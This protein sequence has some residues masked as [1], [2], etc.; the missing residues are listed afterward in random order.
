MQRT[1]AKPVPISGK[2]LLLGNDVDLVITPAAAGEGILFERTD[3]EPVIQ[4]PAL[5][6]NADDRARRTTLTA[7]DVTIE[8]VEHLM[9][10]LYG[11]GIDN[12]VIRNDGPE[13]PCADG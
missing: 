2:G 3:I 7:G 12:A 1:V 5:V 4:I 10:A 6:A 11:V 13:V 9:S 8:T